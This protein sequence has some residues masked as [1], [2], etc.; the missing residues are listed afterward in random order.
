M[1][2]DFR[3]DDMF[4][5]AAFDM[6]PMAMKGDVDMAMADGAGGIEMN[7]MAMADGPAMEKEASDTKED[8][9]PKEAGG[10]DGN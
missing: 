1:F 2:D 5:E 4:A 6:A 3:G 9:E 7:K 8:S 10:D